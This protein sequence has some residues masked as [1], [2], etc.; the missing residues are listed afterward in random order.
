[1]T[2]IFGIAI[3]LLTVAV[4]LIF[5][6]LAN[7]S[8]KSMGKLRKL[9]PKMLELRERFG[10]DKQRLNQEMMALY[11]REG[12]NPVSGCLPIIIQIPVFFALYKVLFVSIEMRHAPFFGW[13]Q[14]LSAP[15]ALFE[16]GLPYVPHF[17]V[18]PHVWM[19]LYTVMMF[20]QK[21]PT[22]P[23]QRTMQQM[24]RWMFLLFGVLLYNYASGL[25]LYMCTSMALAF[26]EMW[27]IKRILGP[28][29]EV[30]GIPSM[31]TI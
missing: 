21:L 19:A 16:L 20:R 12:A 29:P 15:D 5:F 18:L 30:A 26:L 1:V 25:L 10:D 7:K 13:I 8:Y 14:D 28:M 23:Q 11:K 6:P 24:M 4:K 31:P 2:G 9:Q 17:N 27:I 22:D 3:L